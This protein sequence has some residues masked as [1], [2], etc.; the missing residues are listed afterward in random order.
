MRS[1]PHPGNISVG[2]DQHGGGSGDRAKYR[3]LPHTTAIAE[4]PARPALTNPDLVVEF[5]CG[6]VEIC[7]E[8]MFLAAVRVLE[9]RSFF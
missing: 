1:V 8:A 6:C 5:S 4:D 7:C 9:G 2:P 3:K